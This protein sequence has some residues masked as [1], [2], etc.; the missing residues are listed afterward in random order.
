MPYDQPRMATIEDEVAPGD[1]GIPLD[2]T[3]PALAQYDLTTQANPMTPDEFLFVNAG[4][5]DVYFTFLD[6]NAAVS[7]DGVIS[8]GKSNEA[9]S[10]ATG[11]MRVWFRRA[12]GSVGAAK[13]YAMA[14]KAQV[15]TA[16]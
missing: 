10:W 2:G 9:I 6:P 7:D 5:V 12:V 14:S 3:Y 16:P 15:Y 11:A 1:G 8:P 4:A 13:V